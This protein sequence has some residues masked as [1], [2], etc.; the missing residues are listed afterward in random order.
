MWVLQDYNIQVFHIVVIH[1]NDEVDNYD[2][3]DDIG[4]DDCD[5]RKLQTNSVGIARSADH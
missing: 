4:E 5:A 3:E 2:D 1:D